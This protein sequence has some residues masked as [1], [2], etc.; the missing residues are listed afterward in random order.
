MHMKLVNLKLNWLQPLV[1][2]NV[3]VPLQSCE[4]SQL[5]WNCTLEGYGA[6]MH[7]AQH[8]VYLTRA[9]K[10]VCPYMSVVAR[11]GFLKAS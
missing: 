3:N 5:T 6:S 10:D 8:D 4:A 2:E 7:S 9:G 1:P 11:K